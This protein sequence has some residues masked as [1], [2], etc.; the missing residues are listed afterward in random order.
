MVAHMSN[1]AT[2]PRI[3]YYFDEHIRTAITTALRARGIDVLTAQDANRANQR[4]SDADQLEFATAGG[5]VF[6]SS[7][8]DFLN[9]KVVPQLASSAHAG[10]V[11]I[12]QTVS[13]GEQ[14]RFLLYLARTETKETIAGQIRY[15]SPAPDGQPP[16][17]A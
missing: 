12:H 1:E 4:I 10:I 16:P 8:T 11:Y 15:Y 2:R 14:V 6:V 13:I 17:D 5:R 3:S 9:P 7:D